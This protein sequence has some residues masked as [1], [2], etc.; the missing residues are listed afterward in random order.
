MHIFSNQLP[1]FLA[2]IYHEQNNHINYAMINS[3]QKSAL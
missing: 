2:V 1:N 3:D